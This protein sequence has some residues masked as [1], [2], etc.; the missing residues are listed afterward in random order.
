MSQTNPDA[1]AHTYIRIR[2]SRNE[3]EWHGMTTDLTQRG[4]R[5]DDETGNRRQTE[6]ILVLPFEFVCKTPKNNK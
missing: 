2:H 1:G 3:R 5:E 4:K 6:H